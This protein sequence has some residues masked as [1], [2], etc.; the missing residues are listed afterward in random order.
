[1]QVEDVADVQEGQNNE[2][3][4]LLARSRALHQRH[5]NLPAFLCLRAQGPKKPMWV[6]WNMHGGGVNKLETWVQ[7]LKLF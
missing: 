5:S 6:F 7:I 2:Q 3:M 1:M 4:R